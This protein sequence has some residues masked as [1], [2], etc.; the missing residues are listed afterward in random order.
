MSDDFKFAQ[1]P[2]KLATQDEIDKESDEHGHITYPN[3]H[4]RIDNDLNA[5]VVEEVYLT[6]QDGFI[7][8]TE[9][10]DIQPT[11]SPVLETEN[12]DQLYTEDDEL[13]E[14]DTEIVPGDGALIC[15]DLL[16]DGPY[17]TTYSVM[18]QGVNSYRGA[19]RQTHIE[20]SNVSEIP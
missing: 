14:A 11:E 1:G 5:Y 9:S 12:G 8:E 17:A 10:S 4:R 18:V 19:N 13:L 7:L 3:L 6:T 16:I 20:D 2:A 15:S